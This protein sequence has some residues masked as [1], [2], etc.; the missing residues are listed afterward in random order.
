MASPVMSTWG[1]D[2]VHG[3][4][5]DGHP[6]TSGFCRAPIL[7]PGPFNIFSNDLDTGLEGILSKFADDIKLGMLTASKAGKPCRETLTI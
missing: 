7:G 5:L 6:V 2:L 4:I 3:E 1:K